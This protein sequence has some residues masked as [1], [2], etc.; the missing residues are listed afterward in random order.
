MDNIIKRW[1]NEYCW[2]WFQ[3]VVNNKSIVNKDVKKR[4]FPSLQ[5]VYKLNKR[6]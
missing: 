4:K 5:H 1:N 3:N 6:Q 2:E